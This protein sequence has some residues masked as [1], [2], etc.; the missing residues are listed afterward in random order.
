MM[1]YGIPDY[2]L[3]SGLLDKEIN[4]ILNL[5]MEMKM[6]FTLGKDATLEQLKNDGYEAVFLS[7]G[8]QLSRRIPLEGSDLPDVLWGVDFLEKVAEG[9]EVS[10]KERVI[11]IGGGNTAIDAARTGKV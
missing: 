3:P 5:G 10:L 9:Q 7:T 2:R 11:V 4:D 6:G 8:A 1:R